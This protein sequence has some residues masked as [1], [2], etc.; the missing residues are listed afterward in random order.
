MNIDVVSLFPEMVRAALPF[1]I[2]RRSLAAGRL[3]VHVHDLRA[4]GVGRHRQVDDAPFGG[5]GGMVLRPE[6]I[7]AA[8]EAIES[9]VP[10]R[11]RHRLL[12]TPRGHRCE[13]AD[14]RRLARTD[15][16]L[17]VCGRYEGVDERVRLH[18][19]DEDLSIGDYVLSGG[20]LPALVLIEGICRLLPGALGDPEGAERESF[21]GDS[22]DWP[23]WT[24]PATFRGLS[25]PEVLQSGHHAQ[26]QK[27]RQDKQLELTREARP[28][29]LQKGGKG[30]ETKEFEP[31]LTNG[32]APS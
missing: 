8:V 15:D 24:R 14:L 7:F 27:W 1:G 16:L 5:G 17:I 22:L 26:I 9:A 2:V 19:A 6:P 20:E 21:E 11:R 10:R 32:R 25:V 4:H 31:R 12:L 3:T 28:D 29:L 23:A 13:Q 30:L 18:L